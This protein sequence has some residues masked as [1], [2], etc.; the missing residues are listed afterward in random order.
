MLW[1]EK[2]RILLFFLQN[3]T[4]DTSI[5]KKNTLKLLLDTYNSGATKGSPRVQTL[6][7]YF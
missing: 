5:D 3:L 1:F 6:L 7:E 2:K 4:V